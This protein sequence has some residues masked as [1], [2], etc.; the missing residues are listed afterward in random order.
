MSNWT[1]RHE[2]MPVQEIREKTTFHRWKI[3]NHLY[4]MKMC[5]NCALL[6]T[7]FRMLI[8]LIHSES[9]VM[10]QVW[11]LDPLSSSVPLW[12]VMFVCFSGNQQAPEA[13]RKLTHEKK[14]CCWSSKLNG[15]TVWAQPMVKPAKRKELICYSV[16][17]SSDSHNLAASSKLQIAQTSWT[18]L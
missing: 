2:W 7:L 13:R 10:I 9:L 11:Q 5:L 17:Y 3:L 14:V 16:S 18:K 15:F 1:S 4:F 12:D 8:F 6:N